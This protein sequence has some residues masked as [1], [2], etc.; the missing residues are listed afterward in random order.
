MYPSIAAKAKAYF[1]RVTRHASAFYPLRSFR[2]LSPISALSVLPAI[3]LLTG[4]VAGLRAAAPVQDPAAATAKISAGVA[5]PGQALSVNLGNATT[6]TLLWVPPTPD[7]GFMM[8]STVS[9]KNRCTDETQH[10]V[11]LTKGFWLGKTEVTQGQWQAVMGTTIEEQKA[12]A[13]VWL[14]EK[15]GRDLTGKLPICGEGET[16]AMYYVSWEEA[17]AYCQKLTE[18]ERAAGRLPAGYE[19]TL[20]T[21]AQW[22]YACRA[23]S[24]TAYNFGDDPKDLAKHGNYADKNAVDPMN[25]EPLKWRDESADDGY[26]AVAPVGKYPANAWGFQDM[27]GNVYNWCLD[28]CDYNQAKQEVVTDTYRDGVTDPV[29]VSGSLRVFRGGGWYFVAG[30]CRSALRHRLLPGYRFTGLGFRLALSSVR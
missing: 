2:I 10:Q 23:G 12:K 9:E 4:V 11:K 7:G 13:E 20:P 8:G 30:F 25:G 3:A 27:H 19:Y 24:Q 29:C 16:V 5:Q 28:H 22:E 1:G 21:E 26:A 15:M 14:G 18:R 6:L 17:M